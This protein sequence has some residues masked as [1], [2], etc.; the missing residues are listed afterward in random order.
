MR[1]RPILALQG[2]F[3]GH[4]GQHFRGKLPAYFA[5]RTERGP[6]D[7]LDRTRSRVERAID[8]QRQVVEHFGIDVDA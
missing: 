3:P 8:M 5:A 6:V 7:R 4:R 1:R 2:A